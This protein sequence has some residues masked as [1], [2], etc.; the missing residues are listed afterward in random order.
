MGHDLD[1]EF[2]SGYLLHFITHVL[3]EQAPEQSGLSDYYASRVR[4]HAGLSALEV[5]VARYIVRN[6]DTDK[7]RII[8]IGIG[9]GSLTAY[10]A[11]LGYQVTGFEDDAKRVALARR[12]R[13]SVKAVWP[14]SGSRYILVNGSFPAAV[15]EL[16]IIGK[17]SLLLFSNRVDTWPDGTEA[18][19][20]EVFPKVGDVILDLRKFGHLRDLE[21]EREDLLQRVTRAGAR[22]ILQVPGPGEAFYHH[23]K[24]N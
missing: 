5:A 17:D 20:L 13:G 6:F 10:L 16:G 18:A 8:E 11:V 4:N 2:Y 9:I 21:S 3:E 1:H 12:W 24:V 19:M 22:N 15:D 7:R 14:E 23:F